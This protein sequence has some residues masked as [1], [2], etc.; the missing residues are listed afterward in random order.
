MNEISFGTL[1]FAFGLTLFAGLSTGIGGALAY[2]TKKTNTRFLSLALGFSAGVMIYVS[3][4]E[5]IVKARDAMTTTMTEAAAAWFTTLAFFGGI[6]LIA[7]ID[8]L[9]PSFENP[10]EVHRI[11]EMHPVQEG[12]DVSDPRLLRMGFFTALAIAIHNFP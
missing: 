5:I 2:F 9:V 8:K 12:P 11:E 1:A 3:F 10:H 4:V 7:A 6:L